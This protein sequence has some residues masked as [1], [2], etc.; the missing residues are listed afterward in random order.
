[1]LPQVQRVLLAPDMLIPSYFASHT[2]WFILIFLYKFQVVIAKVTNC[3]VHHN[4]I[5][6]II[7]IIIVV[8]LLKKSHIGCEMT[9]VYKVEAIITLQAGFVRN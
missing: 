9:C 6:I 8:K 4:I 7:I 3:C 1:M 2:C 5:I